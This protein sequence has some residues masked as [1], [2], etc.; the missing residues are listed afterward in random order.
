[1]NHSLLLLSLFVLAVHCD[2]LQT[3]LPAVTPDLVNYINSVQKDWVAGHN[4]RFLNAD[5]NSI[6]KLLGTLLNTPDWLKLP[7]KDFSSYS[8]VRSE[9]KAT[10]GPAGHSGQ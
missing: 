2:F 3:H 10:A 4:S 7:Q 9:T 1:M 5:T 8:N 6:K